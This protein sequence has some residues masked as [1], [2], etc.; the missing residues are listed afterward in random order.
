[1]STVR[2]TPLYQ[3]MVN[4]LPFVCT[5][6]ELGRFY[7]TPIWP[8]RMLSCLGSIWTEKTD[9]AMVE[10]W[11]WTKA[12]D[13]GDDGA[14]PDFSELCRLSHVDAPQPAW[15]WEGYTKQKLLGFVFPQGHA[16][17]HDDLVEVS[18][19]D[20]ADKPTNSYIYDNGLQKYPGMG[21][22][23]PAYCTHMAEGFSLHAPQIVR[24]SFDPAAKRITVDPDPLVVTRGSGAPIVWWRGN[25]MSGSAQ[26]RQMAWSFAGVAL[27]ENTTPPPAGMTYEPS[28]Q[29]LTRHVSSDEVLVVDDYELPGGLDHED[30]TYRV[31]IHDH[32]DGRVYSLDPKVRNSTSVGSG[33]VVG[34]G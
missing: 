8:V 25:G 29:F 5:D 6:D 22:N 34:G 30:F 2:R 32:T 15:A 33:G 14:H 3:V 13:P 11:R 1:M 31:S 19:Y 7:T 26:A 27:S 4:D 12:A 24:V 21:W 20:Y 16:A 18:T 9:P 17:G 28:G 10:L 23:P